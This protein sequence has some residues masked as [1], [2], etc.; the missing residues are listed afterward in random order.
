M[1]IDMPYYGHDVIQK[2]CWTIAMETGVQLTRTA[3]ELC[4]AHMYLKVQPVVQG[5]AVF[6]PWHSAS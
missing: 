1:Y 5:L 3:R 4:N 2:A 6:S